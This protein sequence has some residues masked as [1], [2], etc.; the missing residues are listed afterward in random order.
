MEK[1]KYQQISTITKKNWWIV[2]NTFNCS[3]W[4]DSVI[5]YITSIQNELEFKDTTDTQKSASYIGTL[6]FT[7][8]SQTKED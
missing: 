7:M 2:D 6:T 3:F 4:F 1:Q 5:I 8:K